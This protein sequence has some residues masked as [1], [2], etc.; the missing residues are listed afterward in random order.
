MLV[1]LKLLAS[2]RLSKEEI[3]NESILCL[4]SA[5]EGSLKW[6]QFGRHSEYHTTL[7]T[8]FENCINKSSA[9]FLECVKLKIKYL[10]R[11]QNLMSEYVVSDIERSSILIKGFSFMLYVLTEYSQL[12]ELT[13]EYF[14]H[15][16]GI[17]YFIKHSSTNNNLKDLLRIFKLFPEEYFIGLACYRKQDLLKL[18]IGN[19]TP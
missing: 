16:N 6:I 15:D 17:M 14:N 2:N 1:I 10:I 11:I 12:R 5:A 7:N 4:A 8:L 13:R 3:V 9:E 19:W 18:P